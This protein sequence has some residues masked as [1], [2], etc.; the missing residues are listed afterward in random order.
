MGGAR[1]RRGACERRGDDLG[2]RRFQKCASV[3]PSDARGRV[4]DDGA[5]SAYSI[6]AVQAHARGSNGRRLDGRWRES[7]T[8]AQD[9]VDQPRPRFRH[10][11]DRDDRSRC[12]IGLRFLADNHSR[13][14]DA[15]WL[16]SLR[17]ISVIPRVGEASHVGPYNPA[18]RNSPALVSQS[19]YQLIGAFVVRH[20]RAYIASALM[21]IGIAVLTVWV[22]RVVGQAVDGLV[23]GTLHGA[24][25]AR[26]LVIAA[27][28]GGGDLSAARRL[29]AAAVSLPRISSASSFARACTIGSRCKARRFSIAAHRRLDGA[30]DQRCRFDRDGGRRGISGR[31]RRHADADLGYR[32]D[33]ARHRLAAGVDRAAAVSADGDR[34]LV[35]FAARAHRVA[36]S[37]DRF[38]NLN[39]H[40]QETIA[41]VR[42]L[43]ALGLETQPRAT[44]RSAP[45]PRPTPTSAH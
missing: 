37:L 9:G 41:G 40:V 19:L 28:H 30:R 42:T 17:G 26:E 45:P 11:R 7:R 2:Q 4:G 18:P 35:H 12:A 5:L 15:W 6:C 33:G 14:A 39:D 22:P 16:L 10:D 8:G 24:A 43:R 23:A 21:L 34:V 38:S 3:G 25:L 31:V 44:S 20:W 36:R 1:D 27:D 32:D 13:V 29:A